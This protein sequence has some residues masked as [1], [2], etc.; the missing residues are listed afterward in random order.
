MPRCLKT[1]M[2]AVESI[3]ALASLKGKGCNYMGLVFPPLIC[4]YKYVH[5]SIIGLTNKVIYD[6]VISHTNRHNSC[7]ISSAVSSEHIQTKI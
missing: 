3:K 7:V 1:C 2:L 5:M 6:D 4:N